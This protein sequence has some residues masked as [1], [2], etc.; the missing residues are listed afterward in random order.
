MWDPIQR[1]CLTLNIDS[2]TLNIV[3]TL[4]TDFV[5]LLTMVVGLL[6]LRYHSGGAF[7]LGRLLWKQ[8]GSQRFSFTVVL[9]TSS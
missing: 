9:L 8:V 2:Q 5:L 4:A 6:R 3:I 7:E 1:T